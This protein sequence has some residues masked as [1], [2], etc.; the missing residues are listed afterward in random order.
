LHGVQDLAQEYFDQGRRG[1]IFDAVLDTLQANLKIEAVS[2]M[3]RVYRQHAPQIAMPSDTVACLSRLQGVFHLGLLTDGDSKSQWAKIEA[4]GI[5]EFFD[6]I[7]V[8]GDWGPG[9][10]KP[11]VRGFRDL[12]T[13]LSSSRFIYVADNPVK[14]FIAPRVLGWEA[15]RVKRDA[16]LYKD[17]Q[18]PPGVLLCEMP[19][20]SSLPDLLFKMH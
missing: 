14:D 3:V 10:S 19:D 11:N 15:I 6:A 5:R 17:C 4:L 16:G 7:V 1:D 12:E 13:Q 20:L 18:C 9:Y 2:A 8:T